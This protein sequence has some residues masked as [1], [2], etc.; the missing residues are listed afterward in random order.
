MWE[1]IC[2]HT[3]KLHG[4]AA[5][6]SDFNSHGIA[7]GLHDDD[8]VSD[9]VLPASGALRFPRGGSRIHIPT[10]KAWQPLVGIAVEVI[11]RIQGSSSRGEML[12]VGDGSFSFHTHNSLSAP[13]PSLNANSRGDPNGFVSSS[14]HTVDLQPHFIPIGEW[15]KLRFV[16]DGISTMQLFFN[17]QIVAQRTGLIAGI[18]PVGPLGVSIGN[19]T[20]RDDR[21]LR[22]GEI[23]EVKI[24]RLDPHKLSNQFLSRPLDDATASCWEKLFSRLNE[25]LTGNPECA[26]NLSRVISEMVGQ[27]RRAIAALGPEVLATYANFCDDY[28]RLWKAG[29]L[30]SPEM[31]DLITVWCKFLKEMGISFPTQSDLQGMID[32]TCLGEVL[33][34]SGLFDC[35]PQAAAL[36]Q[37]IA[38][39]LPT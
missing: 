27:S 5:D 34:D 7:Q 3:Y 32:S 29:Q 1:L 13:R 16:H 2:H 25:V 20:D 28:A 37:L 31:A 15:V 19:A 33:D 10:G 23:D 24:W 11:A 39:C 8:F 26:E 36:I 35:D 14:V 4:V 9:G 38:K 22:S 30:D 21:F 18:P 12:V 17:D 6:L